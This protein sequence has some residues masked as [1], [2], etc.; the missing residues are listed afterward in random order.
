[1]KEITQELVRKL[2]DYDPETGVVTRKVSINYKAKKGT[3]ITSVGGSGY[4]RV[5]IKGRRYPLHRVIWLWMEGYFPEH[6]IDHINR[7]RLDNRWENLRVVSHSCNMRNTSLANSST[8]RIRGVHL[9][10]KDKFYQSYIKK[11][12][13]RYNLCWSK[14][15]TEAVAHRLAAE[16]ALDWAGCDSNSTAY[17]Y[18]QNYLKELNNAADIN[19]N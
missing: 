15:F 11:D 19:S 4:Y 14:D 6:E 8:T 12:S 1:M 3:I 7:D 10:K 2:F 16:Q 17:Q 9:C 18:M 5:G 13:K